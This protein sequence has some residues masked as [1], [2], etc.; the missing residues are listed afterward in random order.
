MTVAKL[1]GFDLCVRLRNLAERMLYLPAGIELPDLLRRLKTGK[2]S[3]RKIKAGPD[4]QDDSAARMA[5]SGH[6]LV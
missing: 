1:L 2:A 6:G 5:E 3:E 4:Q